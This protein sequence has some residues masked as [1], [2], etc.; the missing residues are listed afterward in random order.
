[1]RSPQKNQ[2][3]TVAGQVVGKVLKCEGSLCYFTRQDD[4]D[5]D[6]FIWRFKD[7]LN[8]RFDWSGKQ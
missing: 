3:L 8:T 5:T 4:G 6:L 7:G 1:M 2:V